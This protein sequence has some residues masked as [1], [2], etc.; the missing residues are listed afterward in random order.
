M[1]LE[2]AIVFA[3]VAIVF[4]LMGFRGVAFLSAELARLFLAIFLVLFVLFLI[5]GYRA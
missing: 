1:F 4:G 3:V 5:L 2:L